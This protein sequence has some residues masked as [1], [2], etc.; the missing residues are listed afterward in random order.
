[1]HHFAFR[2]HGDHAFAQAEQNLLQLALFRAQVRNHAIQ[3]ARK[4]IE[5]A[6]QHADFVPREDG[7][8]VA[9]MPFGHAQG[10]LV[11]GNQR[12]REAAADEPGEHR[13]Q[14]HGQRHAHDQRHRH[15]QRG[16]VDFAHRAI[17]HHGHLHAAIRFEYGHNGKSDLVAKK[18]QIAR[19]QHGFAG[20]HTLHQFGI[21]RINDFGDFPIALRV[22]FPV[23][24]EFIA[25]GFQH[26]KVVALALFKKQRINAGIHLRGIFRHELRLFG[27]FRERFAGDRVHAERKGNHARHHY[28]KQA[29]QHIAR[30]QFAEDPHRAPAQ[31]GA[32]PLPTFQSDTLFPKPC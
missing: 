16:H 26:H 5:R 10:G 9:I 3:P 1:M 6:A 14:K 22:L 32:N 25:I 8:T 18:F 21:Q 15:A 4:Q 20:E 11:H 2:I 19:V 31:Q 13:G 30:E 27:K 24:D 17:G 12:L 7:H 29:Q 28:H 23:G